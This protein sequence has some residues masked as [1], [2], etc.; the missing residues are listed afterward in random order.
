[1]KTNSSK[2][3]IFKLSGLEIFSLLIVEDDIF[4]FEIMKYYLSETG[5]NVFYA[6]TGGEA[7]EIIEKHHIDLV[8]LDLHLP[9]TDGF[10]LLNKIRP[11]YSSLPVI[12]QTSFASHKDKEKI[13]NAGFD[14]MIIKPFS[15]EQLIAILNTYFIPMLQVCSC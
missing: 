1:M 14:N 9:D 13:N 6:G 5:V 7:V 4:C 3:E 2:F 10:D 12:A 11:P 15:R 8:F